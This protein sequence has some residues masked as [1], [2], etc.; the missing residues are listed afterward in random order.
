[1]TE[2][3]IVGVNGS[4][5]EFYLRGKFEVD[6]QI[7]FSSNLK[8]TEFNTLLQKPFYSLFMIN[9]KT[10][11]KDFFLIDGEVWSSDGTAE[12]TQFLNIKAWTTQFSELNDQLF[13]APSEIT[14]QFEFSSKGMWVTDGTIAG[15]KVL[16]DTPTAK[17]NVSPSFALG[18]KIYYFHAGV[19]QTEESEFSLFE[20]D[21]T[22]E[23]SQLM[24]RDNTSFV[25]RLTK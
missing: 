25:G 24:I 19:N 4:K 21:G 14:A 12:N 6:N 20:S 11:T 23:G 17:G 5:D 3:L 1:M 22:P 2:A 16:I 18:D 10:S 13:F 15:T 8:S 7:L 9:G